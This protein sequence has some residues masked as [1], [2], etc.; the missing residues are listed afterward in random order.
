MKN[1]KTVLLALILMGSLAYFSYCWRSFYILPDLVINGETGHKRA[2]MVKWYSDSEYNRPQDFNLKDG[3]YY[4]WHP[5]E[6]R[7]SVYLVVDYRTGPWS[8]VMIR[9][10]NAYGDRIDLK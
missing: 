7:K 6:Q 9:P 2:L 1:R 8:V 3:F 5:F 10:E 4:L